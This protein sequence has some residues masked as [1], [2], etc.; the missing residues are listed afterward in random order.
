MLEPDR[1]ERYDE[2]PL[3]DIEL[4]DDTPAAIVEYARE[5]GYRPAF[6]RVLPPERFSDARATPDQCAAKGAC[7]S[8][9]RRI[10]PPARR[11]R[12]G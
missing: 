8:P 12:S 11:G 9:A 2:G 3:E 1:A 6:P 7:T 5:H 4:D 10:G